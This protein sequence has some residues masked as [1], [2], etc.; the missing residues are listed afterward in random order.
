MKFRKFRQLVILNSADWA[1][2]KTNIIDK[3]CVEKLKI[4]FD[5]SISYEYEITNTYNKKE[6]I[7]MWG[8]F[9]V[10]IFACLQ[11]SLVD[12]VA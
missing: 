3:T 10:I 6:V 4:E 12:M 5:A 9:C 11:F 8:K 7:N 1:I 2:D